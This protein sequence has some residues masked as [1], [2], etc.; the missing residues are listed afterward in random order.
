MMRKRN[1]ERLEDARLW[2]ETWG[3]DA[4]TWFY[5][6]AQTGERQRGEI[7]MKSASVSS[8]TTDASGWWCEVPMDD[9]AMDFG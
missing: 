9:E 2:V 5:Y 8:S 3:E 6:N 4:Q 1:E 7:T